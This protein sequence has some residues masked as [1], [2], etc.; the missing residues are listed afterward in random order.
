MQEIRS[1]AT[2][3]KNVLLQRPLVDSETAINVNAGES[4]VKIRQQI[5]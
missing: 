5:L 3:N 1:V 4:R 2:G